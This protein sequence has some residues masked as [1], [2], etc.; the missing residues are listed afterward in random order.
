[1]RSQLFTTELKFNSRNKLVSF[2][3]AIIFPLLFVMANE[4]MYWDLAGVELM[5]VCVT[6]CLSGY[7]F[8]E[9]LPA[10]AKAIPIAFGCFA[11]FSMVM[12]FVNLHLSATKVAELTKPFLEKTNYCEGH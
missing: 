2:S 9:C 8:A 1:M 4:L 11:T 7:V 3:T 5:I 10:I 12:F 6:L